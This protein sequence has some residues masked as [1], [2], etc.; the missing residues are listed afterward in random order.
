M[1]PSPQA[2]LL[3]ALSTHLPHHMTAAMPSQAA[4]PARQPPLWM[5][6]HVGGASTQG[7]RASAPLA[8]PQ[9]WSAHPARQAPAQIGASAHVPCRHHLQGLPRHAQSVSVQPP[10][11]AMGHAAL[12]PTLAAVQQAGRARHAS[13]T[14]R[15]SSSPTHRRTGSLYPTASTP[16]LSTA[17]AKI[18]LPTECARPSMAVLAPTSAARRAVALA[19]GPPTGVVAVEIAVPAI[20]TG[21]TLEIANVTQLSTFTVQIQHLTVIHRCL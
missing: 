16:T 13:T 1:S 14:A 20:R 9:A 4:M 5:G 19:G 6:P 15:T 12:R 8:V 3:A 21:G 2:R 11:V 17:A 18:G 7:L 10:A